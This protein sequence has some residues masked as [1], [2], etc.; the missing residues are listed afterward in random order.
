MYII[1]SIYISGGMISF[2]L[3]QLQNAEALIGVNSKCCFKSLVINSLGA[4]QHL[5][6]GSTG[7]ISSP[8]IKSG[9][10][11]MEVHVIQDYRKEMESCSH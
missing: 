6:R 2:M 3:L 7:T 11:T 9:V 5:S 8:F 1:Y 4:T 10:G